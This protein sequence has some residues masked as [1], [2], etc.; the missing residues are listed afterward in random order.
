[1]NETIYIKLLEEGTTVYRPVNALKLKD[2][3]FK[4]LDKPETDEVWEF[5]FNAIV[6]CIEK[7]LSGDFCLIAIEKVLS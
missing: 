3:I 2:G 7:K 1:M 5:Q 6:R 4:I